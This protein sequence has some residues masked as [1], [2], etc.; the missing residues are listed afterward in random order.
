MFAQR[1]SQWS[2]RKVSRQPVG[3][4]PS[5]ARLRTKQPANRSFNVESLEERAL[6]A[7]A[8]TVKVAPFA[9]FAT[10]NELGPTPGIFQFTRTGGDL[11]TPLEV[12]FTIGGTATKGIDYLMWENTAKFASGSNTAYITVLPRNDSQRELNESIV[13]TLSSGT[14]Y[15]VGMANRA[16][17]T[18][19]DAFVPNDRGVFDRI[20]YPT[21]AEDIKYLDARISNGQLVITVRLDPGPNTC[22]PSFP[23]YLCD[24]LGAAQNMHNIEFFLDT[25]QNPATG[26]VRVGHVGGAEYRITSLYGGVSDYH[27]YSLPTATVTSDADCIPLAIGMKCPNREEQ[28]TVTGPASYYKGTLTITVPLGAIGNPRAVDVFAVAHARDDASHIAGSG[29]RAPDYGAIDTATGQVVVRRPGVTQWVTVT[30][31][32]GDTPLDPFSRMPL[33]YDITSAQFITIADQFF[34]NLAFTQ[35]VNPTNIVY[36]THLSGE[37]VLDSDRSLVTGPIPLGED[38]PTWGGDTRLSFDLSG[39]APKILLQPSAEGTPVMF[40][41]DRNDGHWLAVGNTLSLTGSLSLFDAFH[42]A[43]L[44][45]KQGTFRVPTDGSM[46]AQVNT[47][48]NQRL[49]DTLPGQNRV[50]DTG[51]GGVLAPFKWDATGTV[52]CTDPA[53]RTVS[54]TDPEYPTMI[55]GID[56]KRVDAQVINNNLVVKG[57]LTS[58]NNTE[59][60]NL[61]EILLD[62]DMNAATGELVAN[63]PGGA[64][65]GADYTVQVASRAGMATAP[66]YFANL[67][68]QTG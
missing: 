55:S 14:G 21:L 24:L 42:L 67:T 23:Q 48:F 37:I 50:V 53:A 26:D 4:D 17:V 2:N 33:G 49:A 13:L 19:L 60:G 64:A 38:I 25:D 43:S 29:D 57:V 51:T 44:G 59:V 68:H 58:W 9:G 1:L 10:A 32:P 12:N 45:L 41:S 62:T 34:T 3:G 31:T 52:S 40:G 47:L 30:D 54:C 63:G 5:Q 18:V 61:F 66:H 11:N 7:V 15:T 65:L 39:L 16:S 28:L 46:N 22:P 6:M 56:L 27:L 35:P 8:P 20:D 36:G